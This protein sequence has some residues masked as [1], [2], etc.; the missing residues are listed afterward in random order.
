[1]EKLGM[2]RESARLADHL[3]RDG[4]P[5]DEIVYGLAVGVGRDTA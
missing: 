5:V 4:K 2:R 1:M 3:G